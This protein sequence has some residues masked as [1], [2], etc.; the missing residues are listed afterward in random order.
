[1]APKIAM[2]PR[3]RLASEIGT[4]LVIEMDSE[5]SMRKYLKLNLN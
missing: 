1:M 2:A 5:I 3:Q 4:T